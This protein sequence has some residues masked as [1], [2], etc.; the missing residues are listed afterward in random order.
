MDDRGT[1]RVCGCTDSR[2]CVIDDGVDDAPCWWVQPP[3][4][5]TRLGLCSNPICVN[6]DDLA[7]SLVAADEATQEDAERIIALI[8]RKV[9]EP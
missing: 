6:A 7:A 5:H 8:A 9:G 3:D 4:R 1:C 2:A